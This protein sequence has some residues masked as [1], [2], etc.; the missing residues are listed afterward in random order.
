MKKLT[1][2][3][4]LGLLFLVLIESYV[5][6]NL[7][8][9]LHRITKELFRLQS[10]DSID[11]SNINDVIK[12]ESDNKNN[13]ADQLAEN[14]CPCQDK[15]IVLSPEIN[16]NEL[17]KRYKLNSAESQDTKS[18]NKKINKKDEFILTVLPVILENRNKLLATYE[19]LIEIKKNNSIS[20][21][22]NKEWLKTLYTFYGLEEGNIDELIFAVKPNPISL[23]LAQT[24][25][26]TGWGTSR[27]YLK[28]NNLFHIVSTDKNS[29]KR[30][31]VDSDGDETYFK[32]YDSHIESVDDYMA[33]IAVSPTYKN[34]RQKRKE[35]DDPFELAN[36]LGSYSEL[37]HEYIRRLKLTIKANNFQRYNVNNSM[38][39]NEEENDDDKLKGISEI[40]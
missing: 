11:I 13:E 36:E 27:F 21:E 23:T 33:T 6:V 9:K 12:E 20:D 39:L 7:N 32:I 1:N 16:L 31:K 18:Q 14:E 30:I 24:A 19:N 22:D 4:L 34:F 26:E 25:L 15:S 5:I 10:E 37:K 2:K 29:E 38:E 3:I 40:E 35:T 8:G 28:G 17:L